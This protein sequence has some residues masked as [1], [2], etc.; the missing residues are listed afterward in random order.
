M[1]NYGSKFNFDDMTSLITS[2]TPPRTVKFMRP[3]GPSHT[4]SPAEI[5]LFLGL[6]AD[7]SSR[8]LPDLIV[9]PKQP[10]S[11]ARFNVVVSATGASQSLQL[12]HLEN[13][14]RTDMYL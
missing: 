8:D 9:T 13:D 5:F 1:S 3:C 6:S 4:L 10:A 2:A 11:L 12:V 7:P 14:V